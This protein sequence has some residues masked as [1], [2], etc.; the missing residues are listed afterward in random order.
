[1]QLVR[2]R[3]GRI[4]LISR[5]GAEK[6]REHLPRLIQVRAVHSC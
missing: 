6:L 1:M 2:L 3:S 5:M 4:T